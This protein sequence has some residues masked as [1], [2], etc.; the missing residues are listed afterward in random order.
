MA[1]HVKENEGTTRFLMRAQF[2]RGNVQPLASSGITGAPTAC[3]VRHFPTIFTFILK[4]FATSRPSQPGADWAW[5]TKD[6]VS[7][8]LGPDIQ[9]LVSKAF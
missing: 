9:E 7:E 3:T 1:H 8:F 4:D 5:V 6:E 2:L